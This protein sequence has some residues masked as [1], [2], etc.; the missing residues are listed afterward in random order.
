MK[1][2][3]APF[4]ALVF[5]L[6]RHPSRRLM[7]MLMLVLVGFDVDAGSCNG[8]SPRL[9]KLEQRLRCKQLFLGL[10][11]LGLLARCPGGVFEADDIGAGRFE[12]HADPRS[13]DGDVERASPVLM[14]AQLAVL[15]RRALRQ[16]RNAEAKA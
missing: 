16:G 12:L 15:R 10:L 8:P 14:G 1:I 4:L 6:F 13:L 2:G 9:R 5:G 11:E 7:L 3:V